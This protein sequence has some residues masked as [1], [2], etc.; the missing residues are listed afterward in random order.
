MHEKDENVEVKVLVNNEVEFKAKH[1]YR[2]VVNLEREVGKSTAKLLFD[3]SNIFVY[4]DNVRGNTQLLLLPSC[5]CENC[6]AIK[7]KIKFHVRDHSVANMD[8]DEILEMI[9]KNSH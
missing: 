4:R 6:S 1:F 5:D 7:E 8:F 9:M 2:I 3:N